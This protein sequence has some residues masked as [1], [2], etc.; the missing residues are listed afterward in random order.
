MQRSPGTRQHIITLSL[1]HPDHRDHALS[2][3]WLLR[4]GEPDRCLPG[5]QR[6]AVERVRE[7]A[8]LL[9]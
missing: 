1:R 9:A 8:F 6:V 2:G 5:V 3:I 4:T 7:L